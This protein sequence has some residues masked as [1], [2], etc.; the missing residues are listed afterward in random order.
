MTVDF[1]KI[2]DDF[3]L[4]SRYP[5]MAY[6][7]NAAT[8]QKPRSVI[9]SEKNYYINDNA[10]PLRGMYELSL[11]ATETYEAARSEAAAFIHAKESAEIIFVRN[12]T[13]GLN[14]AAQCLSEVLLQEGDE[15]LI[16]VM[17]HHS[18]ILPW[19]QAAKRTGAVL[20]YVEPDA[21]GFITEE[22]FRAALTEQTRIVSMTQMSNVMG[23]EQDVKT[24]ARIAHEAGAVFIADGAQSVPHIPVDVQDLDVDFLAFSGHKM[25]G[26]MG[27]GVLYGKREWLEK[28]P[29]FLTG[30]EMIEYVTRE[31]AT[32]AEIPHKFEAGTVNAGGAAGLSAAIGY[33]NNLGWDAITAQEDAL[34]EY[35]MERLRAVPHLHLI[36]SG[37]F[38]EHHGIYTFTIDGV[39][40]HDVAQL[41]S[42]DNVCIRAGHHCAQPLMQFLGTPS[43]ARASAMFYNTTEEIDRLARSLSHVRESMGW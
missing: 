34:S 26:P 5:R 38:R 16:T 13:E 8:S 11:R 15:I 6:L 7:D 14:L 24:F 27:I 21:D 4:L 20:R 32:W 10:N 19:Q 12:A 23:T 22:A 31:E 41:L 43:T 1:R 36:G 39:H 37:D 18:N 40:P 2:R 3:P 35:M 25:L 30:G 29:P 9:E 42:D 33:Y 28:M 17:E